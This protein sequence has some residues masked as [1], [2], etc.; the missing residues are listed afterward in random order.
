MQKILC[1]PD[2]HISVKMID[3][4][5]MVTDSPCRLSPETIQK[6]LDEMNLL[7]KKYDIKFIGDTIS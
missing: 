4:L 5:D 2:T 1:L 3:H 6:A 7:I